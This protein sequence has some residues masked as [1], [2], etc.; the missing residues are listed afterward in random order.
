MSSLPHLSY[1][2]CIRIWDDWD[3]SRSH[4]DRSC[5]L[6]STP[7]IGKCPL[8]VRL[9]VRLL[10]LR[11]GIRKVLCNH[12]L[13][14]TQ[15]TSTL[16]LCSRTSFSL[17]VTHDAQSSLNHT[18]KYKGGISSLNRSRIVH[19]F[20]RL[21]DAWFKL[22]GNSTVYLGRLWVII[23]ARI[24]SE[25][26]RL[27]EVWPSLSPIS[28]YYSWNCEI[29][30]ADDPIVDYCRM[31]EQARTRTTNVWRDIG[32]TPFDRSNISKANTHVSI[33][34]LIHYNLLSCPSWTGVFSK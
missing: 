17:S 32:D 11:T 19:L 34:I 27:G 15:W 2:S 8:S 12:N 3:G 18:R 9:S 6:R 20:V 33:N 4:I 31:Q 5:Y 10:K 16:S 1:L 22:F 26:P 29:Q 28:L 25:R 30:L 14:F 23:S 13:C 24:V 21:H 7:A